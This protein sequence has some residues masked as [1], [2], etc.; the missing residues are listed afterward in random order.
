MGSHAGVDWAAA[1]H[2][3]LVADAAGEE[4]LAAT[5]IHDEQGLRSLCRQ[6]VRLGVELVAVGMPPRPWTLDRL[7]LSDPAGRMWCPCRR[8][9]RRIP[10]SS[11]VKPL[12]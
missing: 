7:G 12:R 8:R 10:R 4:L 1:K 2:D 3:V 11:V 6:L 9:A 5:F